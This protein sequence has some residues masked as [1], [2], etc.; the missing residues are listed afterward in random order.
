M[1]HKAM[2][3]YFSHYS[4]SKGLMNFERFVKFCKDFG[5]FPDIIPKGKITNFFYTLAAIHAQAEQS[6]H[7]IKLKCVIYAH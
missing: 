6:D 5:L 4:D 7:G 2:L 3:V 1:V